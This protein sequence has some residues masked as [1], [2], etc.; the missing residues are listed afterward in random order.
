MKTAVSTKL[1][2]IKNNIVTVWNSVITFFKTLPAKLKQAAIDMF[3]RLKEGIDSK[4]QDA[5]NASQK[6][7][8]DVVNKIKEFPSKFLQVG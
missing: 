8:T 1:T 3:T 6:V 2:E 5:V 7:G 4:K